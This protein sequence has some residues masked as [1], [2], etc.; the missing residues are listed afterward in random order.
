MALRWQRS[1]AQACRHF[2]EHFTDRGLSKV[3]RVSDRCGSQQG[4]RSSSDAMAQ[5]SLSLQD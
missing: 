4:S 1:P 2:K 3:E 5:A